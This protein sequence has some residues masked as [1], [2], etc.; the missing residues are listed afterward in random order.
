MFTLL[1]DLGAHL[2]QS[3]GVSELDRLSEPLGKPYVYGLAICFDRDGEFQGV[4]L[5]KGQDGI[6]Y[7]F[8][9]PRGNDYTLVSKTSATT[10]NV[11]P[12][13][14]R[15]AGKIAEWGDEED[16]TVALI[17]RCEATAEDREDEIIDAVV[18]RYPDDAGTDQRVFAYWALVEDDDIQPF[19]QT[20]LVKDFL[21]HAVFN[22]YA[23]RAAADVRMLD[24]DGTCSI[25]GNSGVAVYGNFSDIACYNI[26]KRGFITGGFSYAQ[27][28]EN[29]PVCRSCILAVRGGKEF[30]EEH[31]DF[32]M[33]GLNYWLLPEAHDDDVYR[34]LLDSIKDRNRQTLG[35]EARSI[36]ADEKDI[37]GYISDVLEDETGHDPVTLNFFFYESSQ[38]AWRIVG[39]MRRV[40]PSRIQTLYE[41]KSTIE[42]R[43]DVILS[44]KDAED[45]YRF[46]L[47]RLR[48]FC[49]SF[50]SQDDR[51]LIRYLEAI[52]QGDG[53]REKAVLSDLVG[54][55]IS[56]HKDAV[57]EGN[58]GRAR[59]TVRDAWATYRFLDTIDAIEGQPGGDLV[60]IDYD[61][62]NGYT[63]YVDDH[64]D[65]FGDPE[66]TAAFLTG[67]YAGQ[68]MY[69][70]YQENPN[71]DTQPFAKKFVGRKLDR[72]RLERLY[73]DGKDKLNQ[74]ERTYLVRDLEPILAPTWI[75]VGDGWD[76]SKEHTTFAFNLGWTLSR[77][78]ATSEDDPDETEEPEAPEATA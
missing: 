25:C 49:G 16:E 32:Y 48:P 63:R 5:T 56:A 11:V 77:Q 8:G 54:G 3:E 71:R 42:S 12:R 65:F 62:D 52:F 9:N 2:S 57:G 34:V 47:L 27:T 51:K 76:L 43:P 23:E 30:V 17:D 18:D 20:D 24:E 29:F 26:D 7:K 55:I 66:R 38:G 19:C 13:L 10:E 72:G 60:T 14:K 41:A 74:Y 15:N 50:D 36:T 45:G 58:V 35:E 44:R 53:L 31:L 73:N 59:Y 40:L 70:Q 75:E 68:V 39:E 1:R 61:E 78:L 4:R 6:L 22:S 69:A 46:N 67:C 64:P 37:L 21:A 28:T 33:A